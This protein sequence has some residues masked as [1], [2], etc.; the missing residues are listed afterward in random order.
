MQPYGGLLHVFGLSGPM[1]GCKEERF[2]LAV[3]GVSR[4]F[5]EA[6]TDTLRYIMKIE[7]TFV[8]HVLKVL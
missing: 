3:K 5:L 7:C 1:K 6:C 2:H 8:M 4:S